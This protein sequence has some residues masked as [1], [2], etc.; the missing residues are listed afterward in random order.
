[1]TQSVLDKNNST[2]RGSSLP[3]CRRHADAIQLEHVR[4]LRLWQPRVEFR[5]GRV[6]PAEADL[7]RRVAE[8]QPGAD[9][10]LSRLDVVLL[11]DGV[12]GDELFEHQR[13]EVRRN[14][15]GL[16]VK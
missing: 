16:L 15:V 13:Q 12:V 3:Y 11:D 10:R 9:L 5:E 6:R 8:F 1:M 7:V 4:S 14:A 2:A